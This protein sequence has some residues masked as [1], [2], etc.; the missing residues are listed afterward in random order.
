MQVSDVTGAVVVTPV[1][2]FV[3][4]DLVDDDVMI[5]DTGLEV[6]AEHT[7]SVARIVSTWQGVLPESE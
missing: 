7:D 3:Q 2:E 5:L 4:D 1:P 6:W